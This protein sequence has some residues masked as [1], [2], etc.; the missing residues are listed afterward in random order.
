MQK[1]FISNLVLMLVL[2]LIIKPIAIVGIDATVQNR[3]GTADYG[4][5]F[6]LL[7]FS[8]LFNILLD[9]G[10]NNFTTKNIA[11][12]PVLAAKYLGKVLVLRLILFAIYAV[13]SYAIALLLGWSTYE[14]YLLSFLLFNQFLIT[15]IAF[16]RSHFGG[17]LLFRTDA[18]IGV[19][20][21][22]LLILICGYLL[23]VPNPF[24]AIKIEWFIWIQTF[25][26][27]ITLLISGA[28]LIK[29]IGRPAIKYQRSFS[30]AI[31]RKSFPYA[32]L[33]LLMMIYT[34]TDSVM[35]ERIHEN[36]ALES[37]YYAQGF[38]L[39]NAL[40]MFAMLFSS[41]L[42]P[43]FTKMIQRKEDVRGLFASS[44]RLLLSASIFLS[45]ISVFN[46]EAILELIY[47]SDV[48][49]SSKS[50]S[51]IMLSFIG[52][53]GTIL[54]GTLLTAKGDM[55]FLNIISFGGIILNVLLNLLM[56]PEQGAVGAAIATL[57]TQSLIAGIQLIRCVQIF[58]LRNGLIETL[59]FG[60]FA[61]ALILLFY[62]LKMESLFHFIGL[63]FIFL[64]LSFALGM[65]DLRNI[66][67]VLRDKS[68]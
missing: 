67:R 47:N 17:L 2:N 40:F 8:F 33:I 22:A 9:L 1:K 45:L 27:A 65:I 3:V 68:N 14:L 26:Y 41:L 56:I 35:L 13:F 21:K 12:Y 36:G 31:V 25:C 46:S 44:S 28:I 32:L 64:L 63:G 66:I 59:R 10:I 48:L 53:S 23:F 60:G 62:Y 29:K 11:Q 50:F 51:W 61:V 18:I 38:R 55:K 39:L 49:E 7:N 6:S 43:I 5:Y 57:I 4:I 54:F 37:G 58:Q 42:L 30:Y 19:L 34:R 20:D 16:T 15:F 52:M 24:G